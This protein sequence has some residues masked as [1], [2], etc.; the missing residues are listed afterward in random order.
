METTNKKRKEIPKTIDPCF[1]MS[2]LKK[3]NNSFSVTPVSNFT[4]LC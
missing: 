4:T 2:M 3:G 1:S